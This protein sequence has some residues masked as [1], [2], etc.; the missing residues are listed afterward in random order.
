MKSA[1]LLL[2]VSGCAY[3]VTLTSNPAPANVELPNGD[4]VSTPAEVRFRYV[5]FGHQR[6]V[7][8]AR[9]YREGELDLRKTE[10]RSW[11]LLF[12]GFSHPAVFGGAP[13]GEVEILLVPD[14]GPVGSWTEEDVP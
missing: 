1:F 5:P 13:R 10:I 7:A 6:I 9:G 11:R 2:L 3:R 4:R 8:S 14:H 12:G